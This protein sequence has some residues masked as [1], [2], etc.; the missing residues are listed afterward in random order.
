MR[1]A[2]F[3]V[4]VPPLSFHKG[5]LHYFDIAVARL[6]V[7]RPSALCVASKRVSGTIEDTDR[8]HICTTTQSKTVQV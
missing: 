5:A 4:N 2:E 7:G 8:P 1:P 6:L 3:A